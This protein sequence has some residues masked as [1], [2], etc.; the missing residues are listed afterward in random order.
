[1]GA[2]N[3]TYYDSTNPG[4]GSFKRNNASRKTVVYAAANDGMLH[5]FDGSAS[6]TGAGS[7]LFAYIPSFVYGSST[8]AADSGLA[9]LGNPSYDH[10]YYVDATPLAFDV[11]FNRVGGTTSATTSDWR[12][13]CC[14]AA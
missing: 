8:T 9:A 6:G 5:A 7:E 4:Y 11:D 1:M 3:A 12:S 2:P 14:A 10:R 13:R